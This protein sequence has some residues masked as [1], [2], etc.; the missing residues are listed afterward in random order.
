MTN[1]IKF[2]QNKSAP[3]RCPVSAC[4]TL[5]FGILAQHCV[6]KSKNLYLKR[7]G[8]KNG[9]RKW[10]MVTYAKYDESDKRFYS[11]E[12][13]DCDENGVPDMLANFGVDGDVTFKELQQNG[14]EWQGFHILRLSKAC[15]TNVMMDEVS[16]L[17]VLHRGNLVQNHGPIERGS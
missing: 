7:K 16:L 1:I 4:F 3:H 14:L 17:S 5:V 12:L 10:A 9:G 6:R 2:P 8:V 13:E 15:S 11:I